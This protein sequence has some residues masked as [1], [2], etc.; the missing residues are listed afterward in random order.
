LTDQQ[1][2]IGI[3]KNFVP[4]SKAHPAFKVVN[5]EEIKKRFKEKGIEVID[6]ENLEDAERFFC[7][8]FFG[9]RIE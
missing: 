8:D 5:L 7:H 6:D 3:D 2:H 4:A 9:N 1:L